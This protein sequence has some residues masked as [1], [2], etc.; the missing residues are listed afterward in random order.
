MCAQIDG[1]S[2]RSSEEVVGEQGMSGGGTKRQKTCGFGLF[3]EQCYS[4]P[5][6]TVTFT[7]LTL[8]LQLWLLSVGA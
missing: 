4:G 5:E 3:L 6:M 7:S 1:K 2:L 8:S